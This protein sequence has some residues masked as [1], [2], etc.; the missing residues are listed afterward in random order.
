[1]NDAPPYCS[2][3]GQGRVIYNS[4]SLGTVLSVNELRNL[5]ITIE[6]AIRGEV[7]ATININYR[8]M[9]CPHDSEVGTKN[10]L[11]FEGKVLNLRKTYFLNDFDT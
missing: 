5:N 6:T 10:L 9:R 8:E 4:P 1:M 2:S 7:A 3:V 11:L